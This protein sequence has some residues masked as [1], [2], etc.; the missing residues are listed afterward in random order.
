MPSN[1]PAFSDANRTRHD[2]AQP[3]PAQQF[4]A[5]LVFLAEV[6]GAELETH[7]IAQAI[8]SLQPDSLPG[9]SQ[10]WVSMLGQ[11]ASEVGLDLFQVRATL[12][13]VLAHATSRTPLLTQVAGRGWLAV[14]DK[15]WGRV[16]VLWLG[17]ETRQEWIS[18]RQFEAILDE[19]S[20]AL[21]IRWVA[22][23]LTVPLSAG[24][25]G[26]AWEHHP[27]EI[28]PFARLK[29]LLHQE[30]NDLWVV[31]IYSIAV[32]L[33]SLVVPVA[34]QALVNTVAF[35]TVLQPVVVLTFLVFVGLAFGSAMQALRTYVV[36]Q[37]QQRLFVRVTTEV[38]HRLLW[39]RRETFDR[40][41]APE[42]VNRFFD[43]VTVQKAGATLL[44]DGLSIIIQTCVGLTIL[45]L[46][47]PL[48]LAF[49][50]FL[51]AFI[52]VIVLALGRGA[53]RT[54]IQESK[55]KYAMAAWLEQVAEY[56][57]TFK[58]GVGTFYAR[59]VANRIVTEYLLK[60]RK[61]FRIL[62]R[63][64]GGFLVLQTVASAVLLGF[65]GW[66][67]IQRQLTLGQLVAAELIVT[68]VVSGLTK[69]GKKLE[70]FYDLLAA[71]DKLGHLMDLP[72]E[73]QGGEPLPHREGPA[74]LRLRRVSLGLSG[75]TAILSQVSLNIPAGAKIGLLGQVGSGK[76]A[77]VDLLLGLRNAQS[78]TVEIDEK[79]TRNLRLADWRDQLSLVRQVEIFQGTV[80]DN[81][82]VG[83][84]DVDG[85]RLQAALE[86]VGL[87][88][89]VLALPSGM[90]TELSTGGF[91]LSPGQSIQLMLARAIIASPRLLILDEVLDHLEGFD[92]RS[93][94]LSALFGP[95]APWTL[96]VVSEKRHILEHCT[97]VYRLQGGSLEAIVPGENSEIARAVVRS[98]RRERAPLDTAS[99]HSQPPNSSSES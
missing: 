53:V 41:H 7:R 31:V 58:S 60:R 33:L 71:L 38:L 1:S 36:E 62:M 65:G 69:F 63:Q 98:D 68:A 35:G 42:L 34:V 29:G 4:Q 12:P 24:V 90:H 26:D 64:I 2:P 99:E 8:R 76:S 91:P 78:G 21:P 14:L 46:Y 61:H 11:A 92:T 15:R 85:Q 84:E 39:S 51:L 81:L 59:Q 49:D 88:E 18:K 94:L 83:R 72:L 74:S 25:A 66:L 70:I 73:R 47:H 22:C 17:R 27:A 32:G 52:A 93:D 48:L 89:Q 6:A 30:K 96:I 43:V 9:S 5:P 77:V 67:V 37:M 28:S 19:A 57:V 50:L 54:S 23:E 16:R 87:Y 44:V 56:L 75:R 3:E 80:A 40:I 97:Q 13:E 45:A 86:K 55:S 95:T 10:D 82:R 20:S 79:D